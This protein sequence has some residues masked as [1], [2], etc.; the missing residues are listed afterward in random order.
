HGHFLVTNAAVS[1]Y[2]GP[3]PGDAT[4]AV[5]IPDASS[6]VLKHGAA[7][8]DALCFYYD[9]STLGALTG[10]SVPY[11]CEGMPVSNLPHNNTSMGNSDV[12]LDRKPGLAAGNGQ[13]TDVNAN[14]FASDFLANPQN[15]A[16]SPTP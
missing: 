15:L 9:A 7:V 2:D 13:D 6:V 10:C 8:V 3:V 12:T 5:G 4:Y 1:G 14:D 11:T 16:S